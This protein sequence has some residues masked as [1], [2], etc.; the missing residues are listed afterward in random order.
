MTMFS[1]TVVAPNNCWVNAV[2]SIEND[3]QGFRLIRFFLNGILQMSKFKFF[4]SRDKFSRIA[5]MF[6][7]FANVQHN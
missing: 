6:L 5:Q 2:C 7:K 3:V 1:S 4:V